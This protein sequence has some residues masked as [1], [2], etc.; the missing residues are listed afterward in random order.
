MHD[1]IDELLAPRPA[2]LPPPEVFDRT[3][4]ALRWQRRVRQ[5]GG[6]GVLTAVYVAG[7]LTVLAWQPP[8][9]SGS[10]RAPTGEARSTAPRSPQPA[11]SATELELRALEA[12][13]AA[14]VLYRQAGDL[15]LADADPAEAVRCYGNALAAGKPEDLEVAPDDS[16]LLMVIKQARKK[17]RNECDK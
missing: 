15:H 16:W 11:P 14:T 2:A 6:V 4:Q 13:E 5:L 8:E 9:P 7:L 12:P 10:Q 17:E 3:V 1:N